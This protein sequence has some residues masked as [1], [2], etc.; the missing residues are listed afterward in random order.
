MSTFYSSA[1]E[2]MSNFPPSGSEG[3]AEPGSNPDTL[4]LE[5]APLPVWAGRDKWARPEH[6]GPIIWPSAFQPQVQIPRGTTKMFFCSDSYKNGQSSP[7][8]TKM[9]RAWR[10][11]CKQIVGMQGRN[12]QWARGYTQKRGL[13]IAP[14]PPSTPCKRGSLRDNLPL[15][16]SSSGHQ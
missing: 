12:K 16:L 14:N 5:S 3:E 8:V 11:L 13:L 7:E 6:I 15:L 2:K 9:V 10:D 4:D 1:A